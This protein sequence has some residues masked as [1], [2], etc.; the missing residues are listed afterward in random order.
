MSSRIQYS[1]FTRGE[2][3]AEEGCRARK[4]F[5]QDG[6]MYCERGHEQVGSFLCCTAILYT[7]SNIIEGI[8][9]TAQDEDD[10]NAQGAKSVRKRKKAEKIQ[11]VYTGKAAAELYLSCYQLI[12]WKQCHWLVNSKGF[13][14]ELE[15]IV[16]DLWSLRIRIMKA[17][18]EESTE[19]ASTAGFTTSE[20]D[21]DTATATS[22][23]SRRSR[24][25]KGRRER[26]PKLKE[27]LALCY[28]GL[29]LL[30][31]PVSLGDI[32]RWA[33]EDDM[34]YTR[35]VSYYKGV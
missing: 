7:S 9:E 6:K 10:F 19:F 29:W 27:T 35:A 14:K 22:F 20:E 31:L 5:R 2:K 15:T 32:C 23:T 18:A 1:K 13:P 4:Y 34:I 28:L 30:R 8:T 26:L 25:K 21:T 33:A 12:L 16:Q 17:K 3:C 24:G 11:I